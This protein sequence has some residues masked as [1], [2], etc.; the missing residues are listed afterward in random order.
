MNSS[1]KLLIS[2]DEKFLE[3]FSGIFKNFSTEQDRESYIKM[4]DD[5]REFLENDK[6]AFESG[7]GLDSLQIYTNIISA[8]KDL[9]QDLLQDIATWREFGVFGISYFNRCINV[10]KGIKKVPQNPWAF[11]YNMIQYFFELRNNATDDKSKK[12]A[13]KLLRIAYCDKIKSDVAVYQTQTDSF[14]PLADAFADRCYKCP[15]DYVNV[16]LKA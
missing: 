8:G 9:T 13:H 12:E 16:R 7:F 10:Q 4:W 11:A 15:V 3:L 14:K 6:E 2:W 5:L 1:Q